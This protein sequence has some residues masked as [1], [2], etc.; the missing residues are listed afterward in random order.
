MEVKH[1]KMYRDPQI[2]IQDMLTSDDGRNMEYS[3]TSY[4]DEKYKVLQKLFEH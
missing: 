1:I 2:P 4:L 3:N